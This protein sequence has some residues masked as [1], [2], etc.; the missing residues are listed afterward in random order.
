MHEL[1]LAF[2]QKHQLSDQ[3]LSQFQQF[4][5]LLINTNELFNLT[6]ITELAKVIPYHFDDSLILDQAI[7][8]N[9]LTMIADVGSGAGFP[10]IPLKI[11][12]PHVKVLLIEVTQKRQQFLEEVIAIL[13][14]ENIQVCE[15]D[16]RTFLRKTEYPIDLFC[17]RAS[18]Q[19]TELVRCF[20]PS[21]PYRTV[22][23]VYWAA[24][25]WQATSKE[26]ELVHQEFTYQVATKK[27]KLVFFKEKV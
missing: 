27:R 11:K 18:L 19:P 9:S 22:T 14:L 23:M 4:Y 25:D 1:W 6:A 13:G 8:L 21:S 20:Q 3:Q 24:T 17:A 15:L 7:S 16:W 5:N 10:G 2:G 12:Y 26:Q